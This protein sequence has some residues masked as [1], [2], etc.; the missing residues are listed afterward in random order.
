MKLKELRKN[1]NL[2]QEELAR[3]LNMGRDTYKNYEQERTQMNYA[4]L[5]KFANYFDVS[6]DY[7][8]D[9]PRPYDLPSYATEGQKQLIQLILKLSELNVIKAISYCAG[10]LASQQN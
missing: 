1:A 5:I 8:L 4:T 2:T 9:R 6:L 3:E 7:L 10:L